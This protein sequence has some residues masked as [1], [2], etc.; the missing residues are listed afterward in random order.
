[1]DFYFLDSLFIIRIKFIVYSIEDVGNFY[2][3]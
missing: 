3:V 1:M 2:L